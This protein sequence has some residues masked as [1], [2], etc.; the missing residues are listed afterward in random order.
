MACFLVAVATILLMCSVI[1][2]TLTLSLKGIRI[3]DIN[4][5]PT[6]D[7]SRILG[8]RV[9]G[10]VTSSGT[11]QKVHNDTLTS[12]ATLSSRSVHVGCTSYS[13]G[14]SVGMDDAFPFS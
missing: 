1:E 11:L 13:D 3:A 7:Y 5:N 4:V 2:L 10:A 8:S 12:R 9:V 6:K 14:Q